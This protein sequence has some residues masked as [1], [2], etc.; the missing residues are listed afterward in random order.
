MPQMSRV[1]GEQ[2]GVEAGSDDGS[3]AG[4][5]FGRQLRVLGLVVGLAACAEEPGPPENLILISVDTLRADH[6]GSYGHPWV[7]TPY[8]DALAEEGVRFDRVVSAAP[9]TLASHTSMMT[10]TWPHTH[11]VPDNGYRVAPGN[12]MLAEILHDAG[13]RTAG[14]VG[15]YPLGRQTGFDQGFE[16]YEWVN[17]PEANEH[18]GRE[19]SEAALAWLDRRPPGRFF[20]F[21]HYWDVHWPYSP[22]PPWNAMYRDDD[23]ELKGVKAE[24][25]ATRVSLREHRPDAAERSR[26][27]AHLY[28]GG[29]SFA[30]AQVGLLLDGLRERAL[31]D[32]SL[33]VLTSDHGEAMDE[34]GAE[35]WNHGNTLY[36]TVAR[37][38]L[39][40][41][42]PDAVRGGRSEDW[43]LSSVDLVPTLLEL[44]GLSASEGLAGESFADSLLGRSVWLGR[45]AVF[46]QATKPHGAEVEAGRHW[47]NLDKCRAIWEGE[48]KLQECPLRGR[49]ELYDLGADAGERDN[50]LVGGH[51]DTAANNNGLT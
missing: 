37:V 30:D 7:K 14:R 42:L 41:R 15:G 39:I 43:L 27:L 10:G 3:R 20:L 49:K 19:V 8:I 25:D 24:I 47:R 17:V 32:R 31:L 51:C 36:E 13:F 2:G 21:V 48:W 23:L 33:L 9:T 5:A 38:P 28:A 45:G 4:W 40:V 6:L 16:S 18:N 1:G 44:L 26:A 11:G 35:Y 34:H 50:R 46:S 29:V 12:R 22:P